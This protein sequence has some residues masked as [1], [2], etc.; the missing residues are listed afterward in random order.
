MDSNTLLKYQ[1]LIST[2]AKEIQNENSEFFKCGECHG[3]GYK[4]SYVRG[5][6]IRNSI[7]TETRTKCKKCAGTG[8]IDW[9]DNV[10]GKAET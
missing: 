7:G 3:H 8:S 2:K 4:L 10:F 6:F 5:K 9:I 1:K